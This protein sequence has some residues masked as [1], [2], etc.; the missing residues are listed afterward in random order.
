VYVVMNLQV[1]QTAG[2]FLSGCTNGGLL[3]SAQLQRVSQCYGIQFCNMGNL[4]CH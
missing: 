1:S 3:N 2:K 4:Q